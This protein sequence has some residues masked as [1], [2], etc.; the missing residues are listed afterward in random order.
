MESG[1]PSIDVGEGVVMARHDRR[2]RENDGRLSKED[3]D[4]SLGVPPEAY[5]RGGGCRVTA[6]NRPASSNDLQTVK[7]EVGEDDIE[8]ECMTPVLK[9]YCNDEC[10]QLFVRK[11]RMLI[12]GQAVI[13]V[14]VQSKLARRIREEEDDQ[15]WVPK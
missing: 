2:K 13:R 15:S 14:G 1:E 3:F 4:K 8:D 11:S 12:A 7:A 10:E 6:R 9:L 5:S